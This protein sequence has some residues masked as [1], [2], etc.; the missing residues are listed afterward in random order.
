M[1]T[2]VRR[3]LFRRNRPV[4]SSRK[5]TNVATKPAR[6]PQA[7]KPASA[8]TAVKQKKVDAPTI[9]VDDATIQKDLLLS[10][11]AFLLLAVCNRR[12]RRPC[13]LKALTDIFNSLSTLLLAQDGDLEITLAS[14]DDDA[15]KARVEAVVALAAADSAQQRQ[16][17]KKAT[18]T[19][20][21][22]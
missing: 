18:K 9:V 16:K 22:K 4:P 5:F 15:K 11:A 13:Q 8:K 1:R 2:A 19:R 12:K 3:R 14:L 21:A 7:K 17:Q 10:E 6:Q 20:G